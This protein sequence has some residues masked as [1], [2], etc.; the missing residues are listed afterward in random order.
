MS[1]WPLTAQFPACVSQPM[2]ELEHGVRADH[3]RL[4]G[5]SSSGYEVRD[6]SAE[7]GEARDFLTS[8]EQDVR[9]QVVYL[10]Q[11]PVLFDFALGDENELR[12]PLLEAGPETSEVR[13]ELVAE[14]TAWVPMDEQDLPTVEL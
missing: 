1:N 6:G 7:V 13:G 12:S 5:P 9:S 8:L 4:R 10:R 14:V 11:L 3:E 2:R